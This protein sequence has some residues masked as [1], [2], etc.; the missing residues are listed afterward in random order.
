MTSSFEIACSIEGLVALRKN[1]PQA[2]GSGDIQKV[3]ETISMLRCLNDFLSS[4]MQA[5]QPSV[6]FDLLGWTTRINGFSAKQFDEISNAIDLA[7]DLLAGC[8]GAL[9]LNE[10]EVGGIGD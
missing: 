2:E 3:N 6:E 7:R 9:A 4:S 1:L 8:G 5:A 10:E